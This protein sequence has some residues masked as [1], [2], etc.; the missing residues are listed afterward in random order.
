MKLISPESQSSLLSWQSF[1]V[2]Q[3]LFVV[4]VFYVTVVVVTVVVAVVIVSVVDDDV[5]VVVVVVFS[6]LK[7]ISPESQSTSLSGGASR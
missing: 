7:Q 6:V 1:K 3:T 2:K 5:A 4:F